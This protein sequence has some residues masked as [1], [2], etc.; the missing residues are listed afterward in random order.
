MNGH[1]ANLLRSVPNSNFLSQIVVK[2]DETSVFEV[3]RVKL[4]SLK[5]K[6]ALRRADAV[7]LEVLALS[8]SSALTRLHLSLLRSYVDKATKPIADLAPGI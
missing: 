5:K 6:Q 8:Y 4:R 2:V 3:T 1:S 7:I